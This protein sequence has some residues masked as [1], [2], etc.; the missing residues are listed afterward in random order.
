MGF[1]ATN[2]APALQKAVLQPDQSHPEHF[3]G[4]FVVPQD[5]PIPE[6]HPPEPASAPMER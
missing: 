2:S 4:F 6:I 3:L 1:R 5:D